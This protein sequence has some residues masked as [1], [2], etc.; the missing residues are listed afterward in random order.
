[1]PE[2]YEKKDAQA[3]CGSVVIPGATVAVA[4][5]I[6]RNYLFAIPDQSAARPVRND[7][8]S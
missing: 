1:M 3:S 2:C 7:E 5:G 6:F 8:K 4:S